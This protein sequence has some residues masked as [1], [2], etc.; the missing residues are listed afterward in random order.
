[1]NKILSFA[2]A[3]KLV[4]TLGKQ[5]TKTIF[6]SGCFDVLHI[7]HIWFLKA[8]KRWGGKSS[9]FLVGVETDEYVKNHKG[10]SRPYFSQEIR[11]EILASLFCIDY[12]IK[13]D[14][15]RFKETDFIRYYQRLGCEYVVFGNTEKENLKAIQKQV[16]LAG[17]KFKRFY[18]VEKLSSS[19]AIIKSIRSRSS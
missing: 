3:R 13:I 17:S 12:V 1:M 9:L 14:V 2:Q 7:G 16:K 11:M 18:H 4:K 6:T 10:E 5:G 8:V 15:T 19:S